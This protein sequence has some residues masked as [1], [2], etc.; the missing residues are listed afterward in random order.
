[1]L[2]KKQKRKRDAVKLVPE[3]QRIFR[4]LNFFFLPAD[5]ASSVRRQ[6][7]TIALNHGANW[8]KD[9]GVHVQYLIVDNYLTYEDTM[10]YF[11]ST[12]GIE[13]LPENIILVNESYSGDCIRFHGLV[14]PKQEIYAVKRSSGKHPASQMGSQAPDDTL[15]QEP[16]LRGQT[17]PRDDSQSQPEDVEGEVGKD[18]SS[19]PP[20]PSS[21]KHWSLGYSDALDEMIKIAQKAKH[22][23]LDEDE[24]VRT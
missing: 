10:A 4:G 23:S 15:A 17:P 3:A 19:Q 14:D 22:L 12:Y 8:V 18:T 11:R 13:V 6:R 1:M 7:I 2:Q 16:D 21:E 24:E 5:D 20:S 9:F